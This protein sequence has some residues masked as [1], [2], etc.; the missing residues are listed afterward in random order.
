M[1][2]WKSNPR[3]L[4]ISETEGSSSPGDFHPQALTDPDVTVS[5][6]PALIIRLLSPATLPY[7]LAPPITV[8]QA[9]GPD[10]PTPSLHPHYGTSS[11]LRVG[12][13][14]CLASVLS[15]SWVLHL[16]FSLT[17]EATGSQV[18]CKSLDQGHATSTPEAAWAV[19]RFPPNSILN[20]IK[21][22]SFD[23]ASIFSMPHQWFT[24]VRLHDPYLP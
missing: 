13:P 2:I 21:K 12:P 17:I 23:L 11:L 24:V 3:F 18:P 19:S 1:K 4:E 6:H 8:D 15:P 22:P 7:H 20:P 14:L 5:R 9:I 10:D 16:S